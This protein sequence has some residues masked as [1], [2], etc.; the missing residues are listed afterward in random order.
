[1]IGT[2]LGS[3]QL[4]KELGQGGMGVVYLAEHKLVRRRAAVKVLAAPL[5]GDPE[6]VQRFFNE[7]RN[8]AMLKH[9]GLVEVYDYG[10]DADKRAYIVMEYLEGENLR[11]RLSREGRLPPDLMLTF[12]KQIV[13]TLIAVHAHGIIH[14]DLKPENLF[15]VRDTAIPCGVRVKLLDFGLS[16]LDEDGTLESLTRT[17]VLLGT[18]AYVSPEQVRGGSRAAVPRSDIY[19][20]GC[21][22][23]EMAC[24]RPPF[25][26]AGAA[27]M[28]ARHLDEV[29]PAP[30]E[31]VPD[32]PPLID[33]VIRRALAKRIEDRQISMVQVMVELKG[34]APLAS[35]G[36]ACA[37]WHTLEN[38]GPHNAP[39]LRLV[40]GPSPDTRS[41]RTDPSARTEPGPPPARLAATGPAQ[42]EI[43]GM[44]RPT[45]ETKIEVA[46]P[47]LAVVAAVGAIDSAAPAAVATPAA[48]V[49][50]SQLIG[51]VPK[52][53]PNFGQWVAVAVVIALTPAALA[54]RS[55]RAAHKPPATVP[56]TAGAPA[57][58]PAPAPPPT[59]A[60]VVAAPS[61]LVRLNIASDPPGAQV[62]RRSDG[63]LLGVTPLEAGVRKQNTP[64]ELIVRMSGY[65]DSPVQ[66]ATDHDVHATIGLVTASKHT[67]RPRGAAGKKATDPIKDGSFDPYEGQLR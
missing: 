5:T 21:V 43:G 67:A 6:H 31:L 36:N 47:A 7:A 49:A 41:E 45:L 63:A 58:T 4:V 48:A 42:P 46:T 37:E 10:Y 26:V 2:T 38:S 50:R 56:A 17:G 66:L 18:P 9:P 20:L 65:L 33:G 61:D 11:S 64:L 27:E 40:P 57:P 55:S 51:A 53:R 16:R 30:I 59:A 22:M 35:Q 3:Y 13:D 52:T 28:I 1:V 25:Q 44:L 34:G 14:R 60:A 32:L 39:F 15:L 8:A 12:S 62:Y 23:F 54:W 19:A 29:P 24:G